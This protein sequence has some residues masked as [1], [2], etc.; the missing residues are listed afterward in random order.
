MNCA[1]CTR[2]AFADAE[3]PNLGSVWV[4]VCK[5]HFISEEATFREGR[6][7]LIMSDAPFNIEA[8]E[9]LECFLQ[10]NRT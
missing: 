5:S 9:T 3:M 8:D 10:E 1:F 6:A 2:R 7:E 4:Y